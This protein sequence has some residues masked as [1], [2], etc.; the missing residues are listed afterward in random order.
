GAKSKNVAEILKIWNVGPDSVVYVDDSPMELEEV[1]TAFPAIR[2]LQFSKSQP[3][4]VVALLQELRDLFG[5]PATNSEDSLRMAS[6]RANAAMRI[7]ST[8]GEMASGEFIRGLNGAVTF[9]YHKD[10]AN[11]RLLELINK[12]NQFNLNGIRLS[13]GEWLQLLNDESSVV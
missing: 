12:T 7:A 8:A 9:D 10:P 11:K 2:C 1:R 5:K 4:K 6:I 3:A 13:E